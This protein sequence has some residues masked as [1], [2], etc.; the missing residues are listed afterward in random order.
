MNIYVNLQK[1]K[2]MEASVVDL[3]FY[4]TVVVKLL[5]CKEP[6]KKAYILCLPIDYLFHFALIIG[7]RKRTNFYE[8]QYSLFCIKSL[9]SKI[10]LLV[11]KKKKKKEIQNFVTKGK[12]F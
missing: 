8:I 6:C 7:R 9:P 5:G 2:L 1:L 10:S 3:S 4:A 11:L 12:F